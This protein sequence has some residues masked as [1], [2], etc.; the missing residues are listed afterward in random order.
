MNRLKV[1]DTISHSNWGS[2]EYRVIG[3]DG[4]EGEEFY[5][6]ENSSTGT[7]I[8]GS[9][10]YSPDLHGVKVKRGIVNNGKTEVEQKI[11]FM[12][13]RFEKRNEL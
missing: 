1:G 8:E 3:F 11:A 5:F 7:I 6:L 12:Y 9:W 10:W 2:N 13:Q 4:R